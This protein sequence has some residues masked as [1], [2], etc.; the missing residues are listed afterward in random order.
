MKYKI[1]D[2]VKINKSNSYELIEAYPELNLD[3]VFEVLRFTSNEK[4]PIKIKDA[5]SLSRYSFSVSENE[6]LPLTKTKYLIYRRKE[7]EWST[8]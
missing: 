4:C 8:Q 7:K 2:L 5:K 6:I 3:S 1:G